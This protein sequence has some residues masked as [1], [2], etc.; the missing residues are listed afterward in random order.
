MS[1][2]AVV[3]G[4]ERRPSIYHWTFF[5]HLWTLTGLAFAALALKATV[6]GDFNTAAR[7]LIG[8]LLVDFTDG[9]L[10]RLFKVKQRM[11][12]ISGEII[13]YIHDLVG[14]TFVPM[15]FFWKT[16]LFLEPYGFPLVIAATLAATLKYSMKANLL[17]LGYS[18]GAPPIFL[19][20][21]LCYF[22]EIRPMATTIY[23]IGLIV[24]VLLPVRFP[25]TSLVTTHWQPGWQSITNYM[26]FLFVIPMMLWLK[27]A[28]KVIYW[29]LL[30]N[31]LIQLAIF[32]ILLKTGIIK[33]GFNRRF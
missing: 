22:L 8:V 28:P 10:A 32:P 26:L 2:Q 19:S 7:L 18:I 24:L 6:E 5:I 15:F 20:I 29:L 33:R 31:I 27:Q 4:H 17:E 14:L 13:D 11:P 25:I 12:L 16:G 30:A 1:A 9:T 23:T 3:G 21:L